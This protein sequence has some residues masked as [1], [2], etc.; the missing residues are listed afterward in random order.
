MTI[1]WVSLSPPLR[2]QARPDI[3]TAVNFLS[4]QPCWKCTLEGSC[5]W[6]SEILM[7]A[8]ARQVGTYT[9][10]IKCD[11]VDNPANGAG[12]V[13]HDTARIPSGDCVVIREIFQT[14]ENQKE[15]MISSNKI[16]YQIQNW[17]QCRT[18]SNGNGPGVYF[19]VSK[20]FYEY[21]PALHYTKTIN[22]RLHW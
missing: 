7:Y 16:E 3:L 19:D 4:T 14:Y 17:W 18:P 5:S 10:S 9:K 20:E 13:H 1:R 8:R 12:A 11:W 2:Q 22:R 15:T 6:I 21:K